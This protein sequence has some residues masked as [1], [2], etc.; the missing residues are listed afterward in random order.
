MYTAFT[1]A[2]RTDVVSMAPT[3]TSGAT[4]NQE[5]TFIT[6]RERPNTMQKWYN[7]LVQM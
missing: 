2:L 4:K 5:H 6:K 1:K 3:H 7:I